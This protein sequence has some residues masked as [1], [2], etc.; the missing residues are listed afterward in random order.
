MK[1]LYFVLVLIG[2]T[3]NLSAQEKAERN[4]DWTLNTRAYTTN[5]WTSM[6]YSIARELCIHVI[7]D[8]NDSILVNRILPST[9]LIFPIGIKGDDA[10]RGPYDRAFAN[11]FKHIGD[12][13]IGLDASYHASSIGCYAGCYFKSTEVVFKGDG[14]N[15]RG[16]YIMPRAGIQLGKKNG[17]LELGAFYDV[18]VG[19]SGISDYDKKALQGGVGLDFAVGYRMKKPG[20]QTLLQF[21]LPLHNFFNKDYE[22]NGVKPFA[23]VKRRVAYL[24]LTTR[25][26]L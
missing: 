13:A 14:D 16:F 9:D 22:L 2:F 4:S 26:E 3:L 7:K 19:Y 15:M 17:F 18:L 25:K 21:S 24:Q 8:D 6:L 11:P 1:R 5:Y 10:I 23:D 12:Y 20:L